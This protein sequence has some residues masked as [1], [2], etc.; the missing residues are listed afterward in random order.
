MALTS[1]KKREVVGEVSQLLTESKMTVIAKYQGI[2][3]D[4]MQVLRKSG[5]ESRTTLKVI[6]NRLF[7]KALQSLDTHKNVDTKNLKGMLI[8]AFNTEDEVLPAKVLAEFAK[9]H[10]SIEFI[11]A[12]SAEGEVLDADQV[13]SLSSLPSRNEL[14]SQV[15][16]TLMSPIED[17]TN[18]I[19]GSIHS[20]L[21]GIVAGK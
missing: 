12:I 1:E 11:G 19:S 10:P 2:S 8:Y 18:A 7:I 17:I 9:S 3:V 6:K 21:D 16:S 5:R 13:K 14:I 20:I 15:V 4:S